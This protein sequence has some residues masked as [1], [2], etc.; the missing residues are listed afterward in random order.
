[1]QPGTKVELGTVKNQTGQTFDIDV[2]KMLADALSNA[3]KKNNLQWTEGSG[4]RL[5]L[6]QGG[7]PFLE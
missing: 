2:E 4:P 1:V 6:I 5:V 7:S 3:L